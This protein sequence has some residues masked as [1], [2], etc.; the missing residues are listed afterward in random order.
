[1]LL[2]LLI[3]GKMLMGTGV[4]DRTEKRKFAVSNIFGEIKKK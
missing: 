4:T 3:A 1:M 2:A